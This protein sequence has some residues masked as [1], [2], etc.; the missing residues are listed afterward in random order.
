MLK[1]KFENGMAL[2][3][4]E[5]NI[6]RILGAALKEVTLQD[7][8][9]NTQMTVL[10]S[11]YCVLDYDKNTKTASAIGGGFGHGIGMSQY[12]ADGMA[13]SGKGYVEILGTFFPG[14]ELYTGSGE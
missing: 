5:Y 11:A 3:K 2:V 1:L 10:P 12:G 7:G 8:T 13:K 6:R 14:T 4:N 9:K